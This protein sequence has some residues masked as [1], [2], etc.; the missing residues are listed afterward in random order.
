M[1][2]IA[3]VRMYVG[4][5]LWFDWGGVVSVCRLQ[6]TYGYHT[7]T[8]KLQRNTNTIEPDQYNQWN[9]STNKSQAPEGGCFNIRNMLSVK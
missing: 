3:L 6:P 5:T 4:I 2:C 7:T 8:A 9:N 1:G